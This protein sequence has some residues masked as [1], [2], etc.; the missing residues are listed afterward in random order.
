MSQTTFI[1][2]RAIQKQ[3][4][5]CVCNVCFNID[6]KFNTTKQTSKMLAK[7]SQTKSHLQAT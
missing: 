4:L 3:D 2:H 5:K 7:F 6:S 1:Y